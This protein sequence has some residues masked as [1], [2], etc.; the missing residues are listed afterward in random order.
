MRSTLG[1]E[2]SV[3]TKTKPAIA[4]NGTPSVVRPQPYRFTVRQYD[5]MLELGILTAESR[6]ELLKGYLVV[7]MSRNPPHDSTVSRVNKR[8][9]RVLP[10]DWTLRV[11]SALVLADSE[12]EPDFAIVRG[13]E[14]TYDLRKP[15]PRDVGLLIEVA[16]STLLR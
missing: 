4:K 9:I 1:I 11:Q 3:A 10:A 14:E 16:D 7:K 12:P 13:T 5:L 6:V 15:L 2:M 8:L